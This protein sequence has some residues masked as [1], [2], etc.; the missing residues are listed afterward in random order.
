MNDLLNNTTKINNIEQLYYKILKIVEELL[1]FTVKLSN[2][3]FHCSFLIISETLRGLSSINN[4]KASV[5][6][7]PLR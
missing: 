3:Y 6:L 1:L 5:G 4:I 2:E 7:I